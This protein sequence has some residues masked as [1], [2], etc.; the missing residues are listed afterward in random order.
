MESRV[1]EEKWNEE[2]CFNYMKFEVLFRESGK[3]LIN[4]LVIQFSREMRGRARNFESYLCIYR[5]CR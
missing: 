3:I 2:F 4:K 1:E 5:D